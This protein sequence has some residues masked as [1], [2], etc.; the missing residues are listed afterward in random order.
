MSIALT[1]D[2]RG[3]RGGPVLIDQWVEEL[4]LTYAG[5]YE[6]PFVAVVGDEMQ[7]LLARPEPAVGITLRGMRR[8]EWW[9]GIGVG[10]VALPLAANAARSEGEAFYRARRAVTRAKTSD[11][12]FAIEA[13]NQDDTRALTA[14]LSMLGYIQSKRGPATSKRWE[15]VDLAQSGLTADEIRQA[16]GISKQAVS[17]RLIRAGYDEE[18]EGRWLAE[19][20]LDRASRGVK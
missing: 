7:A 3:S 11:Y 1:I 10:E 8:Q 6:L 5:A 18:Q 17:A 2:Q 20:L 19:Q 9:V 16:L 13:S 4:N 14:A 15:A 12:G